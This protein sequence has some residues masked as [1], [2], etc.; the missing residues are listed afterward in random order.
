MYSEEHR[1][2]VGM[3]YQPGVGEGWGVGF[4]TQT[5]EK[6]R[7]YWSLLQEIL[8]SCDAKRNMV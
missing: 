2:A 8:H 3:K 1:W 4:V 6:A 5:L 7:E